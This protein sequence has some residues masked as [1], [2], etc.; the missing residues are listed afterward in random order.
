MD[1]E[2]LVFDNAGMDPE[3]QTLHEDSKTFD[4]GHDAPEA[5]M[6]TMEIQPTFLGDRV[7][8]RTTPH[9]VLMEWMLGEDGDE[10]KF[11]ERLANYGQSDWQSLC[12]ALIGTQINKDSTNSQCIMCFQY[13]YQL[14]CYPYKDEEDVIRR[15]RAL[16]PNI[17]DM[18]ARQDSLVQIF[19]S[20][21]M[22]MTQEGMLDEETPNGREMLNRLNQIIFRMKMTYDSV[23][24]NRM[25]LR[26]NDAAMRAILEEIN[27]D[28]MFRE[29]DVGKMKKPLQLLHFCYKRAL[30]EN[31]RKDGDSLYKPRYNSE[32]LFTCSFEF[33]SDISDFVFSSV[34]PIEENHYWFECLTEKAGTGQ[35]IITM[36]TKVKSEYLP[37]LD[38]NRYVH[39]WQNGIYCLDLNE[40]FYFQ[41]GQ[42]R[43]TVADMAG[44]LTAIKYHDQVWD[45]EGMEA[46]MRAGKRYHPM[47]IQME[48]ITKILRDQGYTFNDMRFIYAILGRL[49]FP[50][51][52][53]DNWGVHLFC[54]GMAGTG[55]ST[56]LRIVACTYEARDVGHL[57]NTLQKT[58]ALEGIAEKLVYF[59]LD[60]D[61]NFQLDQVTWQ[62]MVVSEEV[63][64]VRKFKTPLTFKWT[65]P[66]AFAANR[67][68]N[69]TD[70]QGSV[71]RRLFMVDHPHVVSDTN[72]NLFEKCMA[73]SDRFMKVTVSLYHEMALQ[74]KTTNIKH[75]LPQRFKDA[76]KR[77]LMEL[78]AINAFIEDMC[79]IG[80]TEELRKEWITTQRDFNAAFKL[81]CQSRAI[82]PIT[83]TYD[84]VM[85][86]MK[87][88]G[89]IM[90]AKP[91]AND[92]HGMKSAY[93]EGL[94]L[95]SE[96]NEFS[97]PNENNAA[98]RAVTVASSK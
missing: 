37:K 95:R 44:N 45:E 4:E 54:Y 17:M 58:F 82:K 30:I 47:F 50:L 34:Y 69:W 48:P 65:I 39:A 41:K 83:L 61:S 77:A 20:L 16:Y 36:L 97:K 79:D 9:D 15:V 87:R 64:V 66:G 55:K 84:A 94:R 88:A 35:H 12:E 70:N 31:Y 18:K 90:V 96:D 5:D 59:A 33:V 78:N 60:I 26:G 51:A 11:V 73:V 38:R 13:L 49:Y 8:R 52:E 67:M 63:S 72:P 43:K 29:A 27:P 23:A 93:Y 40:F 62:S 42:D 86:I 6:E 89:V 14:Y 81:F 32:G 10:A 74:Y 80:P 92:R 46:D 22:K 53:Y 85:P 2:H 21:K 98:D 28:C 19:G 7:R 68:M 25:I 1:P 91:A 57:N 3:F 75:A 56:M 76:E 24:L 71:A